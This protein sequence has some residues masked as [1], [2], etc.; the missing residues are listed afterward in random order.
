MNRTLTVLIALAIVAGPSTAGAH[1]DEPRKKGLRY[2]HAEYTGPYKGVSAV[3]FAAAHDDCTETEPQTGCIRVPI[4]L[5]DRFVQLDIDDLVGG[6]AFV[7]AVILVE[8]TDGHF[9]FVGHVCGS[10]RRAYEIPKG[11]GFVEIQLL[12]GTCYGKPTP[13]VVTAGEVDL[14]FS[15]NQWRR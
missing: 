7:A 1:G 11:Y 15:R 13:S 14:I 2:V 3:P 10:T 6:D 5:R 4:K 8:G 9:D 12:E